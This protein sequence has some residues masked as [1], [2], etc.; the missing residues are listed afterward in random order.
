MELKAWILTC[1]K[2]KGESPQL[3]LVHCKVERLADASAIATQ[4]FKGMH[5]WYLSA[6]IYCDS[7]QVDGWTI[8]GSS[9][10]CVFVLV[11]VQCVASHQ[12]KETQA[13]IQ[14]EEV[15]WHQH[16]PQ[17]AWQRQR[18]R[19]EEALA[20]QEFVIECS[21]QI[22]HLLQRDINI[23]LKIVFTQLHYRLDSWASGED[24]CIAVYL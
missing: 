15:R 2:K 23:S 18:K 4:S 3:L 21:Y 1:P 7:I 19:K 24:H 6:V 14:E 8:Q 9:L 5:V 22:L 20:S 12:E 17:E 10:S 11:Q 16:I 13:Q